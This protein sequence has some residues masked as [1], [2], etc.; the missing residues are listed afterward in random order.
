MSLPHHHRQPRRPAAVQLA[1]AGIAIPVRAAFDVLVP[2]DLQ[3][4]WPLPAELTDAA[5]EAQLFT[6]VGTK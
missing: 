3:R 5:L 2:Q 6:A 4:D 1:K